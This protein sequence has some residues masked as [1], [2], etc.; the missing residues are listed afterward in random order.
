MLHSLSERT[1]RNR[2][3]V[4]GTNYRSDAATAVNSGSIDMTGFE[5]VLFQVAY[6]VIAA[7]AVSSFKIQ[8]SDDNATWTDVAGTAQGNFTPTTDNNKV[9]ESEIFKPM[10]R[11]LRVAFTRSTANSDIQFLQAIQYRPSHAAPTQP[12]APGGAIERFISPTTGTA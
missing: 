12:S 10:K 3:T 9:F 5:G 8:H 11:Y 6:G 1:K 2:L 7:T 4:D